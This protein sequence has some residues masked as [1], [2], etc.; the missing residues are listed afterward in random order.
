MSTSAHA[1]RVRA[2]NLRALATALETTPAMHL[3]RDAGIDTWRGPRPAACVRSLIDAQH[4]VHEAA[5]D[6][7][8]EAWSLDLRAEEIEYL[9]RAL[10]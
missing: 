8:R 3:E 1:L 9:A 4:R 5:E 7:R 10:G 6:L 2:R